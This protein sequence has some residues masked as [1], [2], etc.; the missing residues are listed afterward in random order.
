MIVVDFNYT[1]V[2]I[3]MDRSGSMS[4]IASDMNGAIESFINDQKALPEKC[5]LSIVQF[6]SLYEVVYEAVPIITATA[7][8]IVARGYTAL[9]DAVCKTILNTG[10]RFSNMREEDRPGKVIIVI[11]TDGHENVSKE[12]DA[13]SVKNMVLEQQNTY[14]WQFVF[15]GAN[16]DSYDTASGYGIKKGA[17]LNYGA[18][19]EGVLNAGVSMSDAVM[20]YRSASEE[21]VLT[22]GCSFTQKEQEIGDRDA[23]TT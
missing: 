5:L 4:S 15:M 23:K 22:A 20:R 18:S 17:V 2:T 8:K 3:V 7:P 14:N 1:D 12:F 19:V 21:E 13:L 10:K 16:Q 11:V 9:N 6:D